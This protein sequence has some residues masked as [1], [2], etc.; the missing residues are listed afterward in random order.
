M[1]KLL[2]ALVDASGAKV[3]L[4]PTRARNKQLIR[5]FG[6]Q[7]DVICERSHVITFGGAGI[8]IR[9]RTGNH[10]RWVTPSEVQKLNKGE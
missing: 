9:S 4:L 7:W 2:D 5:E 6:E 1:D 8:F 3:R 10:T